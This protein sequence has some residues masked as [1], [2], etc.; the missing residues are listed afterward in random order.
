MHLNSLFDEEER[1]ISC[2][3]H[4]PGA[5]FQVIFKSSVT[6]QAFLDLK[7]HYFFGPYLDLAWF[8]RL[9]QP[10]FFIT[11]NFFFSTFNR[12]SFAIKQVIVTLN[13]QNIWLYRQSV[14]HMH[15]NFVILICSLKLTDWLQYE[16]EPNMSQPT[17]LSTA[18]VILFEQQ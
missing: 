7:S 3:H 9:H 13:T 6:A 10:V 8:P 16:D 12:P 14:H 17:N 5:N 15:Y 4:T 1:Y 11:H 2:L 18:V